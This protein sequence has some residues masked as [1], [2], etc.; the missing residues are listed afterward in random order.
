MTTRNSLEKLGCRALLMRYLMVIPLHLWFEAQGSTWRL[1]LVLPCST[2]FIGQLA[3]DFDHHNP[4]ELMIVIGIIGISSQ[5][6]G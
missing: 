4:W 3:A 5:T 1:V 6:N 2:N